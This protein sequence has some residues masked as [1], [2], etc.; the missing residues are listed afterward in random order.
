MDHTPK[1]PDKTVCRKSRKDAMRETPYIGLRNSLP[2]VYW[3]YR[4][5]LLQN[6]KKHAAAFAAELCWAEFRGFYGL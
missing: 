2:E 6:N 1:L 5:R 3:K 4:G